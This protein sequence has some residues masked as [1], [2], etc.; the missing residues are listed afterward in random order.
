VCV[1]VHTHTHSHHSQ[2][3]VL[4]YLIYYMK[5]RECHKFCR[6]LS[7]SIIRR[8]VLKVS[9]TDG[10]ESNMSVLKTNK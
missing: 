4:T 10:N 8:A 2:G 5:G 3:N 6:T 1:C 7:A 9:A